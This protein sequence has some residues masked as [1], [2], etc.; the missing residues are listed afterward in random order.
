MRWVVWWAV[1]WT[2]RWAARWVV[3]WEVRWVV[4]WALR[5]E[6][7]RVCAAGVEG[8][9]E[10]PPAKLERAVA[11]VE[12]EAGA[13]VAA[14]VMEQVEVEAGVGAATAT[15]LAMGKAEAVLALLAAM[16]EGRRVQLQRAVVRG[17]GA[18]LVSPSTS[19]FIGGPEYVKILGV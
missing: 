7:P 1:R 4:R 16:A 13:V 14:V 2:V 10:P 5:K 11:E 6:E 15:G 3:W 18:L 12:A 9:R 8:G 17:D 19:P